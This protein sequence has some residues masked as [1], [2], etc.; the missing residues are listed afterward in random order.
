M[1][2]LSSLE[3]KISRLKPDILL[4]GT[5]I[6]SNFETPIDEN[7]EYEEYM[8]TPKVG[9]QKQVFVNNIKERMNMLGYRI[10]SIN[11][12]YR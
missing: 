9:M 1:T 5:G 2:P 3:L 10:D 11:K 7:K 8:N 12:Y 6:H 4:T